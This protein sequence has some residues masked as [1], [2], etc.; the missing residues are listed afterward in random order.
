M[1]FVWIFNHHTANFPSAVFSCEKTAR[2]WIEHNN[3]IGTLTQYPVDI[4]AYDFA[5]QNGYFEPKKEHHSDKD[6]IARFTNANNK[7]FHFGMDEKE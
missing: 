4:S 5:V 1:N 2:E 6:F 7:H 3:C